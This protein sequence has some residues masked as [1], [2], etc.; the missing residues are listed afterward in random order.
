MLSHL[1]ESWKEV[2]Y[3]LVTKTAIS[4]HNGCVVVGILSSTSEQRGFIFQQVVKLLLT[5][6]LKSYQGGI[7][8]SSPYVLDSYCLLLPAV[9]LSLK[10]TK[11][12]LKAAVEMRFHLS[13]F[14]CLFIYA[15]NMGSARSCQGL[16]PFFSLFCS[17]ISRS[18]EQHRL[19]SLV[20]RQLPPLHIISPRSLQLA[21]GTVHEAVGIGWAL[22]AGGQLL[23]LILTMLLFKSLGRAPWPNHAANEA[24]LTQLSLPSEC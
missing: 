6:A 24:W 9:T 15:H 22:N 5:V 3:H 21:E 1:E 18:P 17:L 12:L 11:R 20:H 16:S 23:C 14:C 8:Q 4:Q 19:W 2:T 10:M 7:S 13:S